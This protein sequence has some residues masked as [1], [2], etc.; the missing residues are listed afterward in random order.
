[1]L[2]KSRYMTCNSNSGMGRRRISVLSGVSFDLC[3]FFSLLARAQKSFQEL[4]CRSIG[5]PS[6]YELVL[7]LEYWYTDADEMTP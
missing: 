3:L 6:P 1:M 4:I 2:N 7:V 5:R